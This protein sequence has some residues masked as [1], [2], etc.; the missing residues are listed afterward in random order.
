MKERLR[1]WPMKALAAF[2]LVCGLFPVSVLLGR[3]LFPDNRLLWWLPLL[4]A[5]LWGVIGYLLPN[6]RRLPWTIMG[7]LL[8][9]GLIG[10]FLGSQD[11]KNMLIAL[12]CLLLL[13][14][15][16]PAWAEPVWEEW[17][18][19]YWIGGA[20]LHL[21]GQFL[22]SRPQ[23]SGINPLLM[24]VMLVYAFLLLLCLNREGIREGMH[25]AEK[26]PASIR[27][28]NTVLVTIL[29]LIG[30]AAA[31]WDTL[32]K[33]LDTAWYYL[34]LGIAYAVDYIAGLFPHSESSSGGQGMGMGDMGGFEE[35]ACPSAFAL[36]M[37][38]VIRVIAAIVLVAL[39]FLA[40]RV[41]VKKL[42]VLWRRIVD[43]LRSYAAAAGEDY[44]DEAESTLNWDEKTQSIQD[45]VKEAIQRKAKQPKWE[46]L[47]G[48]ARVRRLYQQYLRRT[49]EA[50][51][52]TA[53]EAM[54]Q[55][56]RL[57]PSVSGRFTD[58]YEQARYS[59]H[60]VSVQ[61]ADQMRKQI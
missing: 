1:I 46:E 50:Q 27:Y 25:G 59:D 22:A 51:G 3:W 26:A 60:D 44:V 38:K 29:F 8:T 7:C 5:Y 17:P 35:A 48:R 9:V 39:V 58:L 6:K 11:L 20:A 57:S 19:G 53:R 23:F 28:R 47:D 56:A 21:A 4:L 42:R 49:P 34:R 54:R 61:E 40:L 55:D 36:F 30:A 33:W 2:A 15:L 52:R 31:S 18:A 24:I 32:A 14:R 41:I 10:Y 37:E 12:P 13:W 43:R 16:P 45:W